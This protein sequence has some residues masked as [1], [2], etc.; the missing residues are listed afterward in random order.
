MKQKNVGGNRGCRVNPAQHRS[1][2]E[3]LVSSPQS[4]GFVWS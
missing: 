1:F 2:E 4:K 3:P